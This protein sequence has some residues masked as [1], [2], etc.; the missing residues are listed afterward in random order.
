MAMLLDG[1]PSTIHD[2]T[3]RDSDLLATCAAEGID[4]TT[5]L[6]LTSQDTQAAVESMLASARPNYRM[7]VERFPT[8][9][10]VAVTP[11]LKRWHTFATLRAVYQD[12]YYSRLND[13]YQAKMR[14]YKEEETT[15]LDDLRSVGLGIVR[16]PLP[17]AAVPNVSM[18]PGGGAGGTVYLAVA[19]VNSAGEQGIVSLP[20]EAD[21]AASNVASVTITSLAPNA[22][23]WNLF[24]GVSPDAL[25]QQN[26]QTLGPLDAMSVAADLLA[27]G[28]APGD[29]QHPNFHYPVPRRILRG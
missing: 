7:W 16:D 22:T 20:I 23:G 12:L 5:K 25:N 11:T 15:A 9:N 6:A 3:A 26:T 1:S 19:Y 8:L 2:L 10:H 17:A 14:L 21:I 4:L 24:A 27:T 18:V 28:P 13:R 29:G